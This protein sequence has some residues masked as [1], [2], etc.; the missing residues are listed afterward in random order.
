MK[1]NTSIVGKARAVSKESELQQTSAQEPILTFTQRYQA[2]FDSTTDAVGVFSL[3]GEI[4]DA[5]PQLLKLSG[6]PYST[7]VSKHLDELFDEKKIS[8]IR[9]RFK[10]LERGRTRKAPIECDLVSASDK[11]C[12][13]EISLSLLKNQY[14]HPKT[15]LAMMRDVRQRKEVEGRLL[16]RA[17]ELQKVFDMVPTILLVVDERKRVRRINR[18]GLEAFG[19]KTM[20]VVGEK[21]GD[22][23][24]CAHRLSSVKGCGFGSP[25]SDC[26]IYRNIETCLRAGE[27]IQNVEA[28][29]VR[30]E[31]KQADPSFY[32]I[33]V[34]PLEEKKKQ[35]AVVSLD[36]ITEQ[37]K[38]ELELLNLTNSITRA[39]MELKKT[40]EDLARSQS[41]LLESQKLEQIGLLASGLAHNLKTPLGGI[42]GYAQ[43]LKMDHEEFEE[44]DMIISEVDVL[45]SIINNLTLKSRKDH[46][47]KEEILNLNTVLTIELEFL[48][49]NMFFKHQVTKEIDLDEHLPPVYGLYAHF[50]QAVTNII[51]NALDAMYDSED[52]RLHVHTRHDEKYVYIEISDTGSGI[53]EEIREKVFEVF[54]T[55]KPTSL[56]RK[57]SEPFGTGLG[58]AS[59]N[60]F[61]RQYGGKIDIQSE[62]GEG[63]IVTIRVPHTEPKKDGAMQRILL[64]D[65]SN[66]LLDILV[67]VCEEMDLE[68]YAAMDGEKALELYQK[69]NPDLIVTDLCMPGLTGPEMMSRIR[70][71]NPKQRVVYISGYADNPDFREWL[72]REARTPT[73][74]TVLKKPFSLDNFRAVVRQMSVD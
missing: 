58:L 74:S 17:E 25:C 33:S 45:E 19:K 65:D 2:F 12:P 63:T 15:I 49:A 43:L 69:R 21:V 48:A 37:K 20:E 50:S 28:S 55:T 22:V 61:I 56:E 6:Y 31:G 1:K 42:K 41:Q 64:V 54:F 52:K 23:M 62:V 36:D 29:I 32:K 40:L 14:G 60:Y 67:Q 46:Q 3:E 34:S 4:L 5:N 9:E 27:T 71:W 13:L 7:L 11:R 30:M 24:E 70:E 59:A 26:A 72:E 47:K 8:T 44:L 38:S 51:Q 39:N 66:T 68:V 10:L 57:G 35:R 73:L 16:E 18:S 53:P